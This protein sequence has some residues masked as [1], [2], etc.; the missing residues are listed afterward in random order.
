MSN[1]D[2][3]RNPNPKPNLSVPSEPERAPRRGHRT[4][5]IGCV[6]ILAL[7]LVAAGLVGAWYILVALVCMGVMAGLMFLIWGWR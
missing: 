1:V 2:R 3:I 6:V 4:V 5:M 7:A